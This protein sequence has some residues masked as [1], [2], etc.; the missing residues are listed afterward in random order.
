MS[1]AKIPPNLTTTNITSGV[2]NFFVPEPEALRLTRTTLFALTAALSLIGNY[3]VCRA[4]WRQPGTKPFAHYLVSNLAFAELLSTV[5]LV[6]TF[7]AY[8]PPWSWKLGYFMCK[9]L[10]PLQIACLLVITTTLAIIAFYRCVLMV[11]PL[12]R[13]PSLKKVRSLIIVTWVGS[14]GLSV[15]ASVFRVVK[16]YGNDCETKLCQEVFPEGFENYQD[17]YSI[18]L[19][20]VNFGIPLVIIAVCYALVSKKIKEHI[21]VVS[22]L[23]EAQTRAFSSVGQPSLYTDDAAKPSD[24]IG[25]E[26]EVEPVLINSRSDSNV[27][28]KKY[29]ALQEEDPTRP[30]KVTSDQHVLHI[31]NNKDTFEL[32]NDLLKMI[33]IIVLVF[34]LCYIPYQV[35]FLMQEFGVERFLKWPHRYTFSRL[36]FTL[37]C[38]PSALHPICYGMM[39][40]FY[41]K[42]FTR[43]IA[44]RWCAK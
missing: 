34:A 24:R 38:L 20:V 39:S 27:E 43:I 11:K 26:N 35:Q 21:F 42:A 4:V 25:E 28:L 19:F 40:K 17:I 7:H 3:V 18:V 23:R 6:F 15:P 37:T 5:C 13:K 8:E 10:E 31:E 32:E 9:T 41:R 14:I 44:C 2:S 1:C 22:R 30:I 29:K 33:F 36:V 16:S 12:T